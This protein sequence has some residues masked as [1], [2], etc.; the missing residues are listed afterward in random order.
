[1]KEFMNIVDFI[2]AGASLDGQ[3]LRMKI[4]DVDWRRKQDLRTDHI[5]LAD[6]IDYKGPQT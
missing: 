1:M 6:A 5:E 4:A 2:D 3:I